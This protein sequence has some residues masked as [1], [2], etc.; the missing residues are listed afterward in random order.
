ME[1]Q[2]SHWDRLWWIPLHGRWRPKMYWT[3]KGKKKSS[4]NWLWN[5]CIRKFTQKLLCFSS[6]IHQQGNWFPLQDF[7]LKAQ[8]GG[9][10]GRAGPVLSFRHPL[11]HP[12]PAWTNTACQRDREEEVEKFSTG[13]RHLPPSAHLNQQHLIQAL[14]FP[15]LSFTFYQG[16]RRI[17]AGER[18]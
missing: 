6:F 16:L 13:C 17:T 9:L 10:K 14:R 4:N 18:K 2:C 3:L 8:A 15:H 1:S 11:P 12:H 7:G 5:R